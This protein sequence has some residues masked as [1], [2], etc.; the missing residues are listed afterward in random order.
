MHLVMTPELMEKL[1]SKCI[2]RVSDYD[3]ELQLVWFVPR[4][5][6]PKKTKNGKDY[7]IL[8]VIDDSSNMTRIRCWGI[9]PARD[10]L[11]TNHPYV[12]RLE[13]SQDWGFS[14]RSIRHNFR[15]LS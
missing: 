10:I 9:K 11:L 5:I 6:I 13:H 15:M 2:P 1:E 4:K 3:P 8:E 12:A 7:W 14:T